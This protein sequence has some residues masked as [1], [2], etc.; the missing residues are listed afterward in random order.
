VKAFKNINIFLFSIFLLYS[1]NIKAQDNKYYVIVNKGNTTN[2]IN[3]KELKRIYLKRVINWNDGTKIRPINLPMKSE[4]REKFCKEI[5]GKT[6][7]A[8]KAYWQRQIFSGKGVP[9]PE[10]KSDAAVIEY[11]KN[12]PSA[13]GYISTNTDMSGVKR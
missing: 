7:S 11:V 4:T 10:K 3:K 1:S 5:H 12:N 13:I 2:T 6:T 9:P 8:M